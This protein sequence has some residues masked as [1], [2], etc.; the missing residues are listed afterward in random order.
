MNIKNL[1]KLVTFVIVVAGGNA[2][3]KDRTN[4]LEGFIKNYEA[5]VV[6]AYTNTAIAGFN[7]KISGKEEDY[8]KSSDLQTKLSNIYADKNAYKELKEINNS[9]AVKDKDLKRQMKLM[10][11]A[12]TARQIDPKKIEEMIKLQ[13]EMENKFS[14]FRAEVNGKKITDNDVESI[15]KHSTDSKELEQ[16][17]TASKLIGNVVASDLKKLVLMRNKAAKEVGFNNFQEMMLKLDEQDPKEIKKLF[18]ELDALTRPAFIKLKKEI[19]AALAKKYNIPAS[20]LMPWHYQNRYF[21]EAPSIYNVDFDVYYKD[22]DIIA[23]TEKYY[24]GIGMPMD[25]LVQKS[26]LYEKKGKYQHACEDN[27]NRND[28]IRVIGNI[29]PDHYWM[30]TMLHEFG[31]AV[32][33]KYTDHSMPWTFREPAHIFT[34][35]AIA[36]MFGR[37]ATNP[38]W[39]HDVVGISKEEQDKIREIS[40]KTTQMR[41]LI[42]SRWVQVMYRFEKSMYEKPDQDLN[43]L[44][45]KLV[46]KYQMVKKPAGRN[47]PDWASKIHVVTSPVYY[48][49]YLM[50]ELLA[51]Q[52]MFYMSKN[53]LGTDNVNDQS[54]AN[55]KEIGKY[56]TEKVFA[57]GRK[58][59]WNDMI[60]NAT[61]E[62]LTA[63]YYAKQF[64]EQRKS[65]SSMNILFLCTGNSCRSQMAEGLARALKKPG[66]NVYSAGIKPE[67]A[68]SPLAVQAMNEIGVDISKQRPKGVNAIKNINFDYV[69]TLSP[70]AEKN[71]PHFPAKTKIIHKNFKD[72]MESNAIEKYREVRDQI[73]IFVEE[74]LNK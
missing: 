23:L 29:K 10:L 56:L 60:K 43:A 42:F 69:I 26:D 71:C 18:D 8:K 33:D 74:L 41:Q 66:V 58:Y 37:L 50:G 72:P 24:A 47:A 13:T 34:T 54:Y 62:K 32:Y 1:I 39:L 27:M 22:K 44:W 5:K 52:L 65:K 2:M 48:H 40:F 55:N 59:Y 16:A 25:D 57:P 53:I 30:D 51:S 67:K 64:V 6:P 14:T 19:D 61:G 20:K 63:K 38:Q 9:G 68:I 49:N 11:N 17:W 70:N 7:A 15:L 46:E 21:Q 73:N 36:E 31:H 4:E 35:E 12:Y 28:D 45:W 3:A